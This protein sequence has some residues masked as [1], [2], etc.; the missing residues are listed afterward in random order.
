MKDDTPK[1]NNPF[2]FDMLL[3]EPV[4]EMMEKGI[5]VDQKKKREFQAAAIV[6]Y[7]T[8]QKE[9]NEIVGRP[10][11]V[12]SKTLV[13]ELLYNVLKLP[14]K[15][16]TDKKTKKQKV[17]ADEDA[18][19]KTMAECKAKVDDLKTEEARS[20]YK[21]GYVICH[22][23]LKIR[24][25]RKK[26]SSFLG[27]SF[28]KGR[29]AGECPLEDSDGRIRGT[30]SVGG[31]E[32]ARFSHSK[33]LWE[34][35][36]NMATEP[37]K[38][39]PMFIPDDGYEFA[40]F[41]LERGESWVYAHLSE[42]PEMLRIHVHGLD[43]HAETASAISTAFGKP[44]D[45]D[46]I[47]ENKDGPAYKI[48]YLGKRKNHAGSY[49]MGPVKEAE[50]INGEAEDTG[51]TVT[52]AQTKKSNELWLN[53][54]FMIPSW[55]K[56]IESQLERNR[57]LTTPYGR[58]HQFHGHWGE[59]LFRSAT[60]YVPQSTSVDYINTGFLKVYYNFQKKGAWGLSVLAQT[61]DS[62]L[63]QYKAECRDEAIPEIRNAL[64]S[65]LIIKKREF[66]IPVEPSYGMAWGDGKKW[67]GSNG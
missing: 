27:L 6:E 15:T 10:F 53:K 32:T 18:L 38:I 26:M 3:L 7:E 35:G 19:R 57:T 61:H 39:R 51:I 14:T 28:E 41:D 25:V 66:S 23:I 58:I 31:T 21:L 12:E 30:I 64:T 8:L 52:V 48:R 45:V 43:F 42:D 46:W 29:L 16:K 22:Y 62:L 20:R 60:A 67:K 2:E 36:I 50:I 56:E 9:L 59:E 33:T 1:Y 54:Y 40:E 17:T 13:P 24:G 47:I 37:R 49:R 63:V 44:L 34:T 65:K 5:R 4:H 55:W 11:N